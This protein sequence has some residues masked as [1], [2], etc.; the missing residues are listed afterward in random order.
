VSTPESKGDPKAPHPDLKRRHRAPILTITK[1]TAAQR[2]LETAISLWFNSGDPVSIHTLAV[3][4]LD[5]LH[6]IGTPLGKPSAVAAWTEAQSKPARERIKAAQ[7]FFK[8]GFRDING[9]INYDPT[10][11]E[12]LL[13]NAALTYQQIFGSSSPLMQAF[14]LRFAVSNSRHFLKIF[15]DNGLDQSGVERLAN[16]SRR[17]FLKEVLPRFIKG[18]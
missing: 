2:Q 5:C 15:S 18:S 3:A 4:A 12:T 17:E 16:L 1:T 10:H 14:Q 6:A 8:H 7:N 9:Q 13:S 11:G